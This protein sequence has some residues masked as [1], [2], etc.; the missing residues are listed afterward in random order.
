MQ[1]ICFEDACVDQLRPIIL[2]R[3]AY[4]ISCA[5]LRLIDWLGQIPGSLSVSVRDH[6]R[7]LEQTDR[8]LAPVTTIDDPDGVLLVNARVAPRVAILETLRSIAAESRSL[9][10]IDPVD[11]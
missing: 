11:S 3:P 4:A 2:A 10:I 9:T 8:G 1:I 7:A 6:L 5:S